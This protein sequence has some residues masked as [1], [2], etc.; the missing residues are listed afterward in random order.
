[1]TCFSIWWVRMPA[2]RESPL[3]QRCSLDGWTKRGV[4]P[5]VAE[6]RGA[7]DKPVGAV[8]RPVQGLE[9][10]RIERRGKRGVKTY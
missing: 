4:F 8:T 2:L 5:R 6:G 1:M 3:Q 9:D 10:E 7:V